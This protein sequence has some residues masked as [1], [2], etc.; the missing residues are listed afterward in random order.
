MGLTIFT[1]YFAINIVLAEFTIRGGEYQEK[2]KVSRGFLAFV[3]TCM[4]LIGIFIYAHGA[5]QLIRK[6]E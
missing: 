1:V 6:G 3:Y 4:V 5:V 2:E